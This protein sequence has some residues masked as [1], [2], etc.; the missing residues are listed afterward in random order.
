M[1]GPTTHSFLVI[2]GEAS[3]DR[4]AAELVAALRA[5]PYVR[6]LPFAPAFFGAGGDALAAAGVDVVLDLTRHAV[7]GITDV[8]RKVR[9]FHRFMQTLVD[10]AC[11][12]QPDAIICVDFSGFNRRFARALRQRLRSR[13]LT[14]NNW[15]PRLVQYVSPQ[16]WASR[17][18]RADSLAEDFDLLLCLFPFERDWYARRVP[19]LRVEAVGHPLLDRHAGRDGIGA[20]GRQEAGGQP[21]AVVLLPGSR[22]AELRR[23]LPVLLGAAERIRARCAAR[24]RLVLPDDAM[25]RIAAELGAESAPGLTVQVGGLGAALEEAT[26][27]LASTGTV[28]LECA[29][30]GVPTVALYRT[31][32]LT[33]L[34][35]RQLV[36]VKQLAMPNVLLDEPL[37]P[38]FIQGAATPRNLAR[39]A[40]DWIENPAQ[41]GRIRER[42]REVCARLGG[43][44]ASARAA[45]AIAR[46]LREP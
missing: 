45:A 19:R 38:E 28:T 15:Q 26:V 17:P 35:A 34:L 2:A 46:L 31:S 12:R 39:A 8:A 24:F 5:D 30:W 7:V 18:G 10:L 4:L 16:V 11:A 9:D 36:T 41:C 44:G 42:L 37:F 33:Y 13:S 6:G 23:H 43:P 25:R 27:A 20:T 21:P 1:S 3:G 14:F 40:L 32:W 29:W 22:A